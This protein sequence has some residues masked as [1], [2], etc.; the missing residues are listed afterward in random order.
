MKTFD[1]FDKV[2]GMKRCRKRPIVVHAIQIDEPFRVDTLEGNYK[3]GKV[4][5]YLMRGFQDELY[6]CDK[7][8]FEATYDWVQPTNAADGINLC[9]FC[10]QDENADHSGCLQILSTRR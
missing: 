8:I 5:D 7:A 6:I 10:G 3:Q 1:T 9:G 4:G 2:V